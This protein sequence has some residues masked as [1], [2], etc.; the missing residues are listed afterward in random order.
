MTS[1]PQ[2]LI[3][4]VDGTLADTEEA[5]RLSFNIAFDHFG[6]GWHWD[7]DLYRRL[8]EVTGGKERVAFWIN[9]L[10]APPAQEAA[11]LA[12]IP[13][14]HAV[15]TRAYTDLVARGQVPLRAGVADLL[16]AAHDAGVRL[17]IATT[18]TR[19]NIDALLE[20]NLGTRGL[21]LFDAIAC[22][23]V[24]SEKKPAPDVYLLVLQMLGVS[25]DEA[26]AFEDSPQGLQAAV[27][28]GL[29]T[30]VTSTHWTEGSDF[31]GAAR[32]V[33]DLRFAEGG[34][35]S[36]AAIAALWRAGRGEANENPRLLG[37]MPTASKD[38]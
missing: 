25:A 35:A 15:K 26:I 5:H 19:A 10:A 3:F 11:W 7:V 23:D 31:S 18:T 6:L 2:A 17:G 16:I 38:S 14:W 4:D 13:Q 1:L 24:V 33:T 36:L 8:L 32:V 37:A 12:A 30:V 28:A 22:G 27:G 29:W 34:A 9:S 21:G 20:T